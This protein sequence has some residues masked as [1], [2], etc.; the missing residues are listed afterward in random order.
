VDELTRNAIRK[1]GH[2]L[3]RTLFQLDNPDPKFGF[4]DVLL[5]VG[6]RLRPFYFTGFPRDLLRLAVLII[7]SHLAISHSK[8]DSSGTLRHSTAVS[9]GL[10]RP[11]YTLTLSFCTKTVMV[12]AFAFSAFSP[13]WAVAILLTHANIKIVTETSLNRFNI[14]TS[15]GL[16]SPNV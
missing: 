7:M 11:S 16:H 1:V 4:P 6:R 5:L 14:R 3:P 13:Y 2:R 10:K 8:F 9:P 12:G 15:F